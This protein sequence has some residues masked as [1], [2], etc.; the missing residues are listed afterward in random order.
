M[1]FDGAAATSRSF[2]RLKVQRVQDIVKESY[3]KKTQ[4][5]DLEDGQLK[6]ESSPNGVQV[7]S[8]DEEKVIDGQ[9]DI[10]KSLRSDVKST[11]RGG[12]SSEFSVP[13][14]KRWGGVAQVDTYR[15]NTEDVSNKGRK[16]KD[17]SNFFSR[18]SFKELGC[19]DYII[20]S[21]RNLQYIRPSNIQVS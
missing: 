9:K 14:S 8:Y 21:L 7:E 1:Y 2:G 11:G 10:L 20:E 17:D 13:S 4:G 12:S 16:L 19:S 5:N 18:R 6:G 3:R 15:S